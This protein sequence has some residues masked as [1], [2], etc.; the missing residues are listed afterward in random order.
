M[1]NGF[2]ILLPEGEDN[3]VNEEEVDDTTLDYDVR[4]LWDLYKAEAS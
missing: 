4:L 2:G 1:V 3:V